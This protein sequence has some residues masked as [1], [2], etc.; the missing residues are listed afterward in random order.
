MKHKYDNGLGSI[1]SGM[2]GM[3]S[4][5]PSSIE[6]VTNRLA[7]AES[8][9]PNIEMLSKISPSALEPVKKMSLPRG[10]DKIKEALESVDS[11]SLKALRMSLKNVEFDSYDNSGEEIDNYLLKQNIDDA[12][13]RFIETI[14]IFEDLNSEHNRKVA[15]KAAEYELDHQ[16]LQ[17]KLTF[18][19][20]EAKIKAKYDWRE[21]W[22]HLIIKSL[23]TAL[24]ITL[25][26]FVGWLIHTYEWAHLPY[27]NL[28]KTALSLPK[29]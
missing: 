1:L 10:A 18:Q 21:K 12:L 6:R 29:L 9:L 19:N 5:L 4:P 3:K 25:L 20:E 23:G 16:N 2:A 26:M 14:N 28:F 17:N 15:L 13:A 8:S 22:R 11:D 7:R 27:S 24:F